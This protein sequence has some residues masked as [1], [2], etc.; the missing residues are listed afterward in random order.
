MRGSPTILID[1]ADPFAVGAAEPSLSCRLY[2][3]ASGLDGSPSVAQMREVL[4]QA[5]GEQRDLRL[6]KA[7]AVAALSTAGRDVHRAVLDRFTETGRPP[8]RFELEDHAR[9]HDV[10]PQSVLAELSERDVVVFDP[11]GEIR[12]A[13]PFS[14]APTV[15]HVSWDGGPA[16]HAMCAIDA[17]GMSAMLRRHVTIVAAEPGGVG[18]VTVEVDGNEARW[19]P[20]SAVVFAGATAEVC[21][22]SADRTCGN[23]N[24]FTDA[25]AAHEWAASRS[26]VTGFVLTIPQ[27][28]AC[29]VAEFG[30]LLDG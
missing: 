2:E 13:Y 18:S 10:D 25:R 12:A 19:T 24:F 3:T 26:D 15:I 22:P 29:G 11:A 5:M 21:C 8:T 1:G 20:E 16:A 6:N 9:R 17:L 23:I 4:A 27:A 14:P 7:N 28:L 30:A